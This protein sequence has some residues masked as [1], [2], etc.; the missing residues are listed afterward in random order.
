MDWLA[1]G[2]NNVIEKDIELSAMKDLS[3]LFILCCNPAAPPAYEYVVPIL[4]YFL[5]LKIILPIKNKSE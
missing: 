5:L 2:Q 1:G 4:Q 3:D